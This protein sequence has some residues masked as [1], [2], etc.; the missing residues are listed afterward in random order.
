[1]HAHTLAQTLSS[2]NQPHNPSPGPL[3]HP[4]P[5][6]QEA[7]DQFFALLSN[8]TSCAARLHT[9]PPAGCAASD[10][11]AFLRDVATAVLRMAPGRKGR[12]APLLSLLPRVGAMWMVRTEPRIVEQV[13][14]AMGNDM[15]ASTA[16]AFFKGLILHLRQ[17]ASTPSYSSDSSIQT[18]D[19]SDQIMTSIETEVAGSQIPRLDLAEGGARAEAGGELQRWCAWWLPAVL[20]AL[21]GPDERLRTYVASHGL[22][23]M[24]RAE[25]AL[26]RMLLRSLLLQ[27]G[28]AGSGA[29]GTAGGSVVLEHGRMA[30]VVVVLRAG[31]QMLLIGDL[32]ELDRL[33]DLGRAG[34]AADQGISS[35]GRC[36]AA[37]VA[38]GEQRKRRMPAQELLLACVASSSEPL[39]LACLELAC[40]NPR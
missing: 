29:G 25:P 35:Q 34:A 26:L 21:S 31:R 9:P 1:M 15:V 12:Y 40:V 17:E 7:F 30:G 27:A 28:G 3:P 11:N 23:V 24:L 14:R 5:Q 2:L 32:E 39:R 19:P 18:S 33:T 22:P 37:A 13:L 10:I 36:A 38:G 20:Q 8:Q 4:A 6:I 16:T